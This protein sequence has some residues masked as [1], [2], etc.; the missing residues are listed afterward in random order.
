MSRFHPLAVALAALLCVPPTVLTAAPAMARD[1]NRNYPHYQLVDVGSFGGG[2]GL[3]SNPAAKVMND[4]GYAVGMLSTSTPDPYTPNCFFDCQVDHAFLRQFGKT[5]D[6]GALAPGLSSFAYGINDRGEVV[7]ESQNGGIDLA[8]GFWIAR[9]F[10]WRNGKMTELD[11]LGGT[12]SLA[13]AIN[14]RGLIAGT[15]LSSDPDPFTGMAV[16]NCRWT[17]NLSSACSG[18]DFGI[19]ALFVPTSTTARAV[20]W[21]RGVARDLGTLG[22]PDSTA[23]SINFRGQVI[24]WSYTSF[25]PNASGVPD[26]HPFVWENG[27]MT[28]LGSLGGSV[29]V[30]S[31]INQYGMIT[32]ASNTEG[33]AALHAFVWSRNKGMQDIGTLGGTYAHPDWINDRGDV[34]G[35]STTPKDQSGHNLG[36]AFYWHDGVMKNLGTIS[37]DEASEAFSI[38]N[39]CQIVGVTFV[40]GGDDL[41]GFY[42]DCGGPL[43]ALDTLVS[44]ASNIHISEAWVINDRGVIA[45]M[46][47]TRDGEQHPILLVPW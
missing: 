45:G 14:N 5:I 31:F 22:G 39:R 37:T 29:A 27:K 11:T 26:V 21:N 23:I 28:D 35:Y 41:N 7:G 20:L 3:F 13:A 9:G 33:D 38:N 42:S 47:V 6:L 18:A 17:P 2:F 25:T 46:G 44:P 4:L 32:G 40:R 34:V 15:S 30:P 1:Q 10:E 16:Q 8:T 43:V 36:R 19:N 12:Q 24:G